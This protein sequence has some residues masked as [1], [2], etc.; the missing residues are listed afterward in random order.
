MWQVAST[1]IIWTLEIV[2]EIR[3]GTGPKLNKQHGAPT[4]VQLQ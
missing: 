4:S 2:N 1:V 3:M